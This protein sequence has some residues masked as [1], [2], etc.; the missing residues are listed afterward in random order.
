[1][2]CIVILYIYT[3]PL[4]G[5]ACHLPPVSL[6]LSSCAAGRVQFCGRLYTSALRPMSFGGCRHASHIPCCMFC[7]LRPGC[8]V[9]LCHSAV[10]GLFVWPSASCVTAV[11][12]W[13]RDVC[14][15]LHV[16]GCRIPAEADWPYAGVWLRGC[17]GIYGRVKVIFFRKRVKDLPK[18]WQIYIF[19][20]I[21]RPNIPNTMFRTHPRGPM[22]GRARGLEAERTRE[23]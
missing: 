17:R 19:L 10:C 3:Y 4:S 11:F 6:Y 5:S 21:C 9:T 22:K 20:Y 1:M 8:L 2:S 12:I 7:G 14:V 23:N 15:G 18:F 13:C 16:C